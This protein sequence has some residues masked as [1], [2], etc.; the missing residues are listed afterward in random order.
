[1]KYQKI[2][3]SKILVTGASGFIGSALA[4]K[5]LE[6][7]AEV[8]G[9]S[10]RDME[11]N[12]DIWWHIGD[13]SNLEFVEILIQKVLPDYI[14]HMASHVYGSRDYDHVA[15]T[16][17]NNLVT[18]FNMLHTVHVHPCKRIIF[19]GSFEE[20]N[21]NEDVSIP[22]SPYAAAK[23][24]ASNYA[25]LFHKLYDTPVCMASLYMVYGPGQSDHS[26][27]VPYVTL[28][29]IKEESPRLMSGNRLIDWVYV[30][31]VV[32]GLIDI[33]VTPGIEGQTIDIG[34]GKP[35]LTKEIV[36][37]LISLINPK[38]KPQYGAVDDRP[39]EQERVANVNE[40][41]SKI[42]WRAT[43]DLET[44]LKHTINYYTDLHNLN[45]ETSVSGG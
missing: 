33:L 32:A 2:K 37:T 45:N 29:T 41:Y 42:G 16:F 5:L 43:T 3:G 15:L 24:A 19:A 23:H 9:V 27:L 31:D 8:H 13:L 17:N 28:T 1:M 36:E 4:K 40:T 39:M 34:S 10:R 18:A 6:L 26:K 14:Y 21:S 38:I 35:T 25:R 12:D 30:D 7:G 22:S 20:I 11:T 44:G